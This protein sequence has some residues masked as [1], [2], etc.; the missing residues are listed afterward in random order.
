MLDRV[1]GR[2]IGNIISTAKN[3][4]KEFQ[5][6]DFKRVYKVLSDEDFI[7]VHALKTIEDGRQLWISRTDTLRFVMLPLADLLGVELAVTNDVAPYYYASGKMGLIIESIVK[8]PDKQI[9]KFFIKFDLPKNK[10][11]EKQ[12]VT[13]IEFR[14]YPSMFTPDGFF[15]V[16]L[17]E[18][19][20][21]VK[22][23]P[24]SS[25]PEGEPMDIPLDFTGYWQKIPANTLI[26]T[27]EKDKWD[28]SLILQQ[29][30]IQDANY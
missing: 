9:H 8:T 27:F 4:T 14:N 5:L 26:E 15:W 10:I 29:H 28:F 3:F 22:T 30:N 7:V 1:K 16:I 20:K 23:K 18:R 6:P 21:Y 11:L 19:S 25:K 24:F 12:D 13:D 2:W 17:G